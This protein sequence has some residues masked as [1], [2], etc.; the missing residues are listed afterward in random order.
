VAS[1]FAYVLAVSLAAQGLAACGGAGAGADGPADGGGHLDTPG[2]GDGGDL[3]GADVVAD[4]GDGAAVDG[5]TGPGPMFLHD[6]SSPR[7]AALPSDLFRDPGTGHVMLSEAPSGSGADIGFVLDAVA[8]TTGFSVTTGVSFPVD[9]DIDPASLPAGETAPFAGPAGLARLDG[10]TLVEIPSTV[11]LRPGRLAVLP[12]LGVVL[13]DDADHVA[14]VTSAVTDSAGRAAVAAPRFAA[15]RDGTDPAAAG[16][17]DRERT[18]LEPALTALQAAG[19]TRANL[20]GA[21]RFHTQRIG[22]AVEDALAVIDAAP[23]PEVA[24]DRVL[25][26][27]ADLDDLLGVPGAHLPGTDNADAAADGHAGLAHDALLAV[28]LGHHDGL[29]FVSDEVG[30]PGSFNFGTD[31]RPQP[32]ATRP[33]PFILTL[34]RQPAGGSY[35]SMPVVIWHHGL[36]NSRASVFG[37]ADA[38]AHAGLATFAYDAIFHGGRAAMPVD[39]V[40]N[41]TGADGPDGLAD[42]DPIGGLGAVFS[43]GSS[44][45]FQPLQVR[46]AFRQLCLDVDQAARA[47]STADLTA[48]RDAL[49]AAG[50]T[51]PGLDMLAFDATRIGYFGESLG[52]ITGSLAA[53][54]TARVGAFAL[55]VPGGGIVA[56]LVSYSPSFNAVARALVAPAI[57][58]KVADLDPAKGPPGADPTFALLQQVIDDADPLAY[59]ARGSRPAAPHLL[60]MQAQ[61]DELIPHQSTQSLA[62]AWGLQRLVPATAGPE[63]RFVELAP[64]SAPA[65]GNLA[66]GTTG[67]IVALDPGTHGMTL[68]QHGQQRF[69]PDGPPFTMLPSPLDIANPIITVQALAAGFLADHA[70]GSTPMVRDPADAPSPFS[71]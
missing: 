14:W 70:G 55:S 17:T 42:L 71:P 11:V 38:L 22:G 46:D 9:G 59:A 25:A 63:L 28:V 32:K 65:G 20:V 31:G 33:I 30:K 27:A 1:R 66:G 41:L 61:D 7:T 68:N 35:A 36:N 47:L 43:L 53:A 57:G 34:P 8:Q 67:V 49:A 56:E 62:S 60:M 52:G 13:N 23:V 48:L 5:A 16:V 37:I 39:M 12:R 3:P 40:H 58:L 19:V 45:P 18:L 26:S 50:V 51:G 24:V 64:V 69:Q 44:P 15:L 21:S 6:P 29:D 10:D 4:G 54:T 2:S